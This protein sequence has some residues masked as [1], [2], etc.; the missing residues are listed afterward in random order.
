MANLT[1]ETEINK[2]R[3][4]IRNN[5]NNNLILIYFKICTFVTMLDLAY[6]ASFTMTIVFSWVAILE[7]DNDNFK[8]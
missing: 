6:R 4:L 8:S 3:T 5:L 2:T 1:R 7:S